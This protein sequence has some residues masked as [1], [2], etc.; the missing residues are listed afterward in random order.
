MVVHEASDN[1]TMCKLPLGYAEGKA[2]PG[3]MTLANYVHGGHEL[4]DVKLQLCLKSIGTKKTG[5]PWLV[6]A[7]HLY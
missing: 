1:G 5:M 2:L 3:L 6:P 4:D 7:E